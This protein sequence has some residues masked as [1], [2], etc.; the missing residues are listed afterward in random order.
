MSKPK[1]LERK[2]PVTG[3]PLTYSGKGRPP[4]FHSSVSAADRR[5]HRSGGKAG[6]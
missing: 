1:S 3:Q 5:K 4:V 6:K 2:C